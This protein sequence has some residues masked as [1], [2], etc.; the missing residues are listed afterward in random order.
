MKIWMMPL[1]A[2][3][4]YGQA[5]E[6][7]PWEDR[8]A[9]L[10]RVQ[11]SMARYLEREK[12]KNPAQAA[13]LE[14]QH[15]APFKLTAAEAAKIGP[16]AKQLREQLDAINAEMIAMRDDAPGGL[17]AAKMGDYQERKLQAIRTAGAQ[18]KAALSAAAWK[19]LEDFLA[20]EVVKTGV[21]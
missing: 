15:L 6:F 17:T 9:M 16:V 19:G 3:L 13:A 21:K 10:M 20:D 5:K 18:L 4:L 11:D 1:A 2:V 14:A 8:F 12:A 7:A